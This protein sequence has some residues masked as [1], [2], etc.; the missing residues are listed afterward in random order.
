MGLSRETV[1]LNMWVEVEDGV[2][3]RVAHDYQETLLVDVLHQ[4]G[5][6]VEEAIRVPISQP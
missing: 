6:P 4:G 3:D 2:E 1:V 5:V